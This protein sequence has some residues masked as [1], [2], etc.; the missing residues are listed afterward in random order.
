MGQHGFADHVADSVDRRIGCLE[1]LIYLDET[2][3][4]DLHLGILKAFDFGVRLAAYRNEHFVEGLFLLY[5]RSLLRLFRFETHTYAALV[6]LHCR[7]RGV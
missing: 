3:R 1:L 6:F 2:A 5:R 4:T 7:N